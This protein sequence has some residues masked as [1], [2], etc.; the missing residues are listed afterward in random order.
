MPGFRVYGHIV[1]KNGKCGEMTTEDNKI[2]NNE[3]E[4]ANNYQY[5]YHYERPR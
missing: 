4:I 1:E 2:T 3:V 5:N